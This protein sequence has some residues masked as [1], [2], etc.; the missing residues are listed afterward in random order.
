MSYM[1]CNVCLFTGTE[2]SWFLFGAQEKHRTQVGYL[3]GRILWIDEKTSTGTAP[4]WAGLLQHTAA[5]SSSKWHHGT[6]VYS[7]HL[8]YLCVAHKSIVISISGCTLLQ[9]AQKRKKDKLRGKLIITLSVV[10]RTEWRKKKS[11]P[12]YKSLVLFLLAR[13]FEWITVFPFAGPTSR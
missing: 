3:K 11:G 8:M 9:K 10:K 12:L 13:C 4:P 1:L 6:T 5:S 7:Y 2:R